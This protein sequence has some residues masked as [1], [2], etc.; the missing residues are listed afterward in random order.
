MVTG[1]RVVDIGG[2]AVTLRYT[3]RQLAKVE[4]EFGDAP[5]LFKVETL[6][7]VAAIGIDR[8]EWTPE[9]IIELSPPMVPFIRA[10]D[11]AV[12]LAYF[13]NEAVPA[14]AEKK[15]L[16]PKDGLFRRLGRLFRQG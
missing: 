3:W 13:G 4:A 9:R 7:R 6:A 5:N 15:S 10:V 2:E 16:P 8:P 12:K 11:E 1:E 14:E